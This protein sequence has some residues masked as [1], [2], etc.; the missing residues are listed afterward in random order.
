MFTA[1]AVSREVQA[2]SG[3]AIGNVIRQLRPLRTATIVS[4]GAEQDI[5]PVIPAQQ[6]ELQITGTAARTYRQRAHEHATFAEPNHY[7]D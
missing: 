1:L 6:Q 2:R 4:D 5:P 7:V 3:L